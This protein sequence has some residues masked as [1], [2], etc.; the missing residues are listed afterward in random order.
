MKNF[1]AEKTTKRQTDIMANLHCFDQLR[2]TYNPKTYGFRKHL[3]MSQMNE[4][5]ENILGE[6]GPNEKSV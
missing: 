5:R 1:L 2:M 4:F 6:G 3:K